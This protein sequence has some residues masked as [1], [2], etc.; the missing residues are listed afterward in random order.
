MVLFIKLIF[1]GDGEDRSMLE[2]KADR[3]GI[4]SR[5]LFLGNR[6]DMSDLYHMA[7]CFVLASFREGLSRSIMEAMACGL[8]CIVSDIRGNRDLIDDHGGYLF[9]PKDV[10]GLAER[11]SQLKD[12]AKLREK[13]SV[14]NLEKIKTFSF[15]RVVNE[16][17]KI[18]EEVFGLEK[19]S[20][21]SPTY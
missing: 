13:M 12:S 11:I 19:A 15:E 6:S 20:C 4:K 17:M 5:V 2:E 8:P 1:C 7:D 18:Y 14:Y 21:D 10:E 16:L 3:L 9:K